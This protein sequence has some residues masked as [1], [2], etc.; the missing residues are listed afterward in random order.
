MVGHFAMLHY[1][2][3][4]LH[5][6]RSLASLG[7]ILTLLTLG[8]EP[9][10]QQV[11]TYPSVPISTDRAL[12]ARASNYAQYSMT[13]SSGMLQRALLHRRTDRKISTYSLQM[14]Q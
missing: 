12:I 8:I 13:V 2:R 11:V 6:V 5:S 1:M 7:A 10:L 3:K 14:Q 9:F 4:C